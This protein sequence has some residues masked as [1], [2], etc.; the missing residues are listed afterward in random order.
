MEL[1]WIELHSEY[2]MSDSGRASAISSDIEIRHLPQYWSILPNICLAKAND[3][4]G[5]R[6]RRQL[7]STS[8][9]QI[10]TRCDYTN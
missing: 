1:D 9:K 8:V 10:C 6:R 2:M 4:T 7:A 5:S 3:V